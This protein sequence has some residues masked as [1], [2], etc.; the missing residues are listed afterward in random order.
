MNAF[1]NHVSD[2]MKFAGA[3]CVKMEKLK[4]FKQLFSV[5]IENVTKLQYRLIFAFGCSIMFAIFLI[6]AV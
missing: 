4:K 6:T 2:V 5:W 1:G 3:M